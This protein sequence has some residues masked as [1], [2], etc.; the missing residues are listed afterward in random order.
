MY[1]GQAK[2]ALETILSDDEL[3][4]SDITHKEK[5]REDIIAEAE[6]AAFAEG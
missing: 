5:S 6:A 2:R 3:D 4:L 1:F